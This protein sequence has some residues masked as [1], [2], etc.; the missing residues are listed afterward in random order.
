MSAAS[1]IAWL[2]PFSP[3]VE[4][5][6]FGEEK[7]AQVSDLRDHREMK[8]VEGAQHVCSQLNG[9]LKLSHRLWKKAKITE[10]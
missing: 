10:T 5:A 4:T 3:P 9:L 1:S 8:E 6:G 7:R 2:K